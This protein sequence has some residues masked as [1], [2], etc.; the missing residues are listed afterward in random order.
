MRYETQLAEGVQ[1]AERL[2]SR[3][4]MEKQKTQA[5]KLPTY[6]EMR[7]KAEAVFA[8]RPCIWQL[9]VVE[10]ILRQDGDITCI[11]GTGSGKTLTF[12]LPL[13]FRAGIQLVVTPLTILGKQ[14]V[15][16]LAKCGIRAIELTAQTGN[17][18]NYRVRYTVLNQYIINNTIRQSKTDSTVSS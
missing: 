8:R 15:Q 14:N 17:L 2:V 18:S 5:T 9:R 16:E 13:L 11:S 7:I 4:A 3:H 6:D 1:V 12:W 10:A